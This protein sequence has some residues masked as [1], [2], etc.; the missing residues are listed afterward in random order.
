M[1]WICYL[2]IGLLGGLASTVQGQSNAD[3]RL[4]VIIPYDTVGLNE[5]FF[6][7]VTL[8]NTQLSERQLYLPDVTGLEWL[9]GTH[10]SQQMSIING[11]QTSSITY[12]Y[13]ARAHALGMA[14][15][16]SFEVETNDGFFTT[17]EQVI[18]VV[19]EAPQRLQDF[20]LQQHGQWPFGRDPSLLDELLAPNHMEQQMDQLRREMYEFQQRQREL[21]EEAPAP[22]TTP[23]KKRKTYRI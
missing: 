23:K 5:L 17:Q 10:T 19:P 13:K 3:V 7:Q 22:K 9:P 11:A 16:P 20:E 2:I 6:V 15:L 21:L 18:A 8:H 1:N 14:I 12:H 4:E